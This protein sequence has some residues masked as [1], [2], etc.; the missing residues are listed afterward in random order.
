MYLLEIRLQYLLTLLVFHFHLL[1]LSLQRGILSLVWSKKV[2]ILICI[3][4]CILETCKC[5]PLNC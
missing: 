2:S 5:I 4:H 3:T 1:H